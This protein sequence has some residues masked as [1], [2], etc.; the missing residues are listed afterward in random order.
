MSHTGR[1]EIF[2]TLVPCVLAAGYLVVL[3]VRFPRLIGWENADSD[4]T[5][6]YVLTDSISHGHTGQVV[7]STQGSWVP[8][9]YGLLTHGL[10]FH[11][12][13]WEMSPALLIGATA[14]LIG[15]SVARVATRAAATLSVGLMVAASPTAL[16]NFSAAFF[17]N[18]TIPGTA[19]LG[20]YL[21]WLASRPRARAHV[22]A[23]VLLLS[24]LVGTFLA[25]D[26][27]LGVVGV[28]PFL[29]VA[30]LLAIRTRDTTDLLPVV[31]LTLGSVAVALLTSQI[32]RALDFHTTTPSLRFT[33]RFIPTHVKWLA[34]GLLRMGNGLS[35]A[36]H[37]SFRTP[38]VV[39]AGVVTLAAL[40]SMFWLAARS[41]MR[42][43]EGKRSQGLDNA[44]VGDGRRARDLH[45]TFWAATL[46]CA[47][48]AYVVTTV[49]DYPT[50]RYF[51]VAVPAVAATVP[52]LL[53]SR[54]ASWIVA[55]GAT[56]F[57]AGSIVA[58]AANDERSLILYPG[59]DVPVAGRIEALV[60]SQ[61]LG[62]GYAGYWNAASLDWSDHE[63][64]RVYPLTDRFGPTQ[65]MYLARVA[66]WYQPR[67]H[68]PSYLLLAPGDFDFANRLPPDLPQP[69][70][71]FQIGPVT[72]AVYPYDIASYFH[73]PDG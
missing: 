63:R 37:S 66:A 61:H 25:S 57:I 5:S 47:A 38:L 7:M 15:W 71:E 12:V 44:D 62:V 68:T 31:A 34:Q 48:A 54:R 26:E 67:A 49:A 70:R 40:A 53:T 17:H 69:K 65:P 6:A 42:P 36:P 46:L 55:A 41:L 28:L 21:V 60:R 50:D 14:I 29:G 16:F 11:R 59:A 58:L 64:L 73:A 10:S 24:L 56:V 43:A 72:M 2:P 19:I 22:L 18:T 8:L 13:L 23:S 20:G 32:M 45:V 39:A 1:R 52:L 3:I 51:I 4:I 35:V 9:W 30:L 33:R 27:L